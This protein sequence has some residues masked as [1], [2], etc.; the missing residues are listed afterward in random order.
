M[1]K[2]KKIGEKLKG[3]VEYLYFEFDDDDATQDSDELAKQYVEFF[4]TYFGSIKILRIETVGDRN[5]SKMLK[6]MIDDYH[7]PWFENVHTIKVY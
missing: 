5:F 1:N 6:L 7:F 4:R 3:K 2:L